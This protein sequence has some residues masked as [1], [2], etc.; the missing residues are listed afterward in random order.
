M[1]TVGGTTTGVAYFFHGK[2]KPRLPI[3]KLVG[4]S[5]RYCHVGTT[6]VD[7]AISELPETLWLADTEVIN[8]LFGQSNNFLVKVISLY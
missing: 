2:R 6:T 1:Q 7:G 5:Y 8:H 3:V 4:G